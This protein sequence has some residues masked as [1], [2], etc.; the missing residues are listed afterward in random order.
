ML[1]RVSAVLIRLIIVLILVVL[2]ARAD[3]VVRIGYIEGGPYFLHKIMFSQ[4]RSYLEDM[5]DDE[6]TIFFEPHAYFSADW[7][8][9]KSRALARDMARLDDIDIA[10]AAGPWVIEDLMA[11]DFEGAIVGINQFDADVSGMI[12]SKATP[13]AP[14][15]TV[16]F[17]PGK[18]SSDMEI[19][20]ELFPSKR[21]G[22][23]YFPSEEQMARLGEKMQSA[24]ERYGAEIVT[25]SGYNNRGV[26]T[27]FKSFNTIRDEIDVLYIT[28]LW[29]M[30][31]EQINQF[32]LETVR[33]RVPTFA[34]EGYLQVEKGATSTNC[35]R[36]YRAL[37]K[38][39][40]YKILRIIEGDRPSSLPTVFRE[41]PGLAL[42][43]QTAN[44]LRVSFPRNSIINASK[45]PPLPGDSVPKYNLTQA[46]E[47]AVRENTRLLISE[48]A[49]EGALAE[50]R[51]AYSRFRPS[52]RL[53]FSA[54]AAAN[55]AEA[56]IYNDIFNR[57]LALELTADQKLF[58]YPAIKAIQVARK[59]AAMEKLIWDEVVREL[60]QA[61]ILAYLT[62]LEKEDR[63]RAAEEV[64]DRWRHYLELADVNAVLGLS[65]SLDRAL[66]EERLVAAKVRLFE[67][68]HDL[69]LAAIIFNVLVNRPGT[70]MVLLDR[71]EFDVE[72]MV[73]IARIFE[74]FTSMPARLDEL[75]NFMVDTGLATAAAM[76]AVNMT[77]DIQEDL[78]AGREKWY[79]PEVGLRARYDYG[80]EFDPE[81]NE[82]HDA[83]TIGGVLSWP[84]FGRSESRG[85]AG[86]LRADLERMIYARDTIRFARMMAI[87]AQTDRFAMR[88]STLPMTYFME[89][90]SEDNLEEVAARYDRGARSVFDLLAIEENE[91]R[92]SLELIESRYRFF[93]SYLEMLHV[94]G[95]DYPPMESDEERALFERIAEH[96]GL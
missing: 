17:Q 75:E 29:G 77:I 67:A 45:V 71:S 3:R 42:N 90:L 95:L 65:D 74:Q 26:Y 37:A 18:I 61:V 39:T 6:V 41:M 91:S 48:A 64:T 4:V 84:L 76:A 55:E 30:S 28:P 52:V 58:S 56:A 60:R 54:A 47:Q 10:V 38:F 32:Y 21:I 25:A 93:E 12:D 49:Y 19:L 40:A 57:R 83:W 92:R 34:A 15:L 33:A 31:L 8:R 70:D 7:E 51:A 94:V 72:H 11:A 59:R 50:I 44:Q 53:D 36:P 20:Q 27:F 68:E 81:I 73:V 69:R 16:N 9:E 5:A 85:G 80:D 62:V 23:L 66:F 86:V 13:I 89:N 46:V 82:R 35:I 78:I 87:M 14:N 22:L 63:V 24:V 88:T 96:L 43:L 1:R 2:S 79:L